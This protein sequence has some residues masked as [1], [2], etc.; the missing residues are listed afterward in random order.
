MQRR[1]TS[2]RQQPDRI[3]LQAACR[4]VDSDQKFLPLHQGMKAAIVQHPRM[5]E[6]ILIQIVGRDK[7]V[8]AKIIEELHDSAHLAI[9]GLAGGWRCRRER[10]FDRQQILDHPAMFIGAERYS[11][12][13]AGQEPHEAEPVQCRAVKKYFFVTDAHEPVSLAFIVPDQ[14]AFTDLYVT[15]C[16]LLHF[17]HPARRHTMGRNGTK[18]LVTQ[19]IEAG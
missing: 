7:A 14:L 13:I 2:L 12:D 3:H 9:L 6:H 11:H 18:L 4:V 15:V 16:F 1:S 17:H 19:S 10:P 5:D 8:S